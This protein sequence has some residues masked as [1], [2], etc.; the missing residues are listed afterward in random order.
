MVE[1]V[2]AVRGNSVL[3][4]PWQG[5]F[6]SER[7]RSLT[8]HFH[9]GPTYIGRW[10][11][12]IQNKIII[13]LL[14]AS[15]RLCALL[16]LCCCSP[17]TAATPCVSDLCFHLT[18]LP[19]LTDMLSQLYQFT[20]LTARGVHISTTPGNCCFNFFKHEIPAKNVLRITKTHNL[21]PKKAF[22]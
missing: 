9:S 19:S 11:S 16:W 6:W 1:R 4:L 8:F 10:F 13:T 2:E 20:F 21:C 14:K 3:V 15:W 5:S 17:P 7:F 22:V 18:A 12:W